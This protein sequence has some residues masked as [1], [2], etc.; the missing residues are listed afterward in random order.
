MD[1]NTVVFISSRTCSVIQNYE[2]YLLYLNDRM[3]MQD[4][5]LTFNM[6]N[7]QFDGYYQ[8]VLNKAEEII[9]KLQKKG[10]ID[11]K[12]VVDQRHEKVTEEEQQIIEG[13]ITLVFRSNHPELPGARPTKGDAIK[14]ISDNQSLLESV[15]FIKPEG[16][17]ESFRSVYKWTGSNESLTLFA[18]HEITQS[19]D[20]EKVK[21]IRQQ[22][23]DLLIDYIISKC[24]KANNVFLFLHDKDLDGYSQRSITCI[25][26]VEE[27]LKKELIKDVTAEK[28]KEKKCDLSIVF[29][30]HGNSRISNLIGPFGNQ[31]DSPEMPKDAEELNVRLKELNYSLKG[32]DDLISLAQEEQKNKNKVD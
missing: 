10:L 9:P 3:E 18:V 21:V 5:G 13:V 14:A 7:N 22:W 30:K 26:S 24:E 25:S 12:N 6:V 16:Q 8:D 23:C 15:G 2:K 11:F 4:P 31:P 1:D 32:T 20:E 27:C 29:F 19:D 28:L 17:S